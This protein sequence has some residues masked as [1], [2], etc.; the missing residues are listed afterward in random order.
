MT[1]DEH[2]VHLLAKIQA[3]TEEIHRILNTPTPVTDPAPSGYLNLP[4]YANVRAYFH[5][6]PITAPTQA[7]TLHR[8]YETD[9]GH[10]MRSFNVFKAALE[11]LGYIRTIE[12]TGSVYYPPRT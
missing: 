6:N 11:S 2:I 7:A 5:T 12:A 8:A 1:R 9:T 10:R 3:H 4:E